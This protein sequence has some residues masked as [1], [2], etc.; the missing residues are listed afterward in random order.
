VLACALPKYGMHSIHSAAVYP[1]P[2]GVFALKLGWPQRGG[3]TL[4]LGDTS[5]EVPV[6]IA[7]VSENPVNYPLAHRPSG[8]GRGPGQR[9]LCR[10]SAVVPHSGGVLFL[11]SMANKPRLISLHCCS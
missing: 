10:A 9:A 5:R 8:R 3:Y 4:S 11:L 6:K 7:V 2:R 1:A